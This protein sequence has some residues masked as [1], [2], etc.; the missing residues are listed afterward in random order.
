[1]KLN[2]SVLSLL[3]LSSLSYAADRPDLHSMSV[4]DFAKAFPSQMGEC[5]ISVETSEGSAKITLSKGDVSRE[6]FL[7]CFSASEDETCRGMS[8]YDG[9]IDLR[10]SEGFLVA[11]MS[12][13]SNWSAP[14]TEY[15]NI[16]LNV[17]TQQ[18]V[19]ILM[20]RDGKSVHSIQAKDGILARAID[21]KAGLYEGSRQPEMKDFNCR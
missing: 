21:Y 20:N 18:D 2:W 15:P 17:Q 12:R 1:M 8:V 13:S 4:E 19:L 7:E 14:S 5:K 10:K 11:S 3:I 9:A 16:T 6:F